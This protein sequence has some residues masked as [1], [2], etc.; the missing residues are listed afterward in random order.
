LNGVGDGSASQST[1]AG[2]RA[3]AGTPCAGQTPTISCSGEV[4]SALG[5][6]TKT[7]ADFIGAGMG[8]GHGRGLARREARGVGRWACSGA[9]RAH[10]TRG[11]VLLPMF[12]SSLRSQ[13]CESWQKSGAGLFLAPM[14]ISC[15]R[16]PRE[17]KP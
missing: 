3:A 12:N 2:D 7:L 6:M 8:R 9:F 17:D 14:A 11:G 5:R 16:V 10:R 1:V 15:M 4:E 13:T